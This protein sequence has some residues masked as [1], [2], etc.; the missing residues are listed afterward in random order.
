MR[1]LTTE[2]SGEAGAV[3]MSRQPA[4]QPTVR[5]VAEKADW[6]ARHQEIVRRAGQGPV[7]LCF[8][9]DSLT[10]WWE[11]ELAARV[12][13]DAFSGWRS[14][15]CGVGGDGTQH[16]LWCLK[17]GA[18]DGAAPGVVV[19]L[20]GT[21]NADVEN[22]C[23]YS[24]DEVVVGV[25]AVA[26]EIQRLCPG[27]RILLMGLLPRGVEPDTP[28]RHKIAEINERLQRFADGSTVRFLDISNR[29]LRSDG[30]LNMDL[31]WDPVHINDRGYRDAH[32]VTSILPYM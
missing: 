27:V 10:E 9:G 14:L 15:N 31:F 16:V 21:N 2:D 32:R 6:M 11:G 1:R 12:W 4:D 17:H 24:A 20:I 29:Y 5:T 26:R 7:D 22:P 25:V 30:A 28:I 18:L 3:G 23:Q 19:L 13:T 8:V